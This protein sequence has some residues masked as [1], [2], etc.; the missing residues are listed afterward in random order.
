VGVGTSQLRSAKFSEQTLTTVT[1]TGTNSHLDN[2]V[3]SVTKLLSETVFII[4]Y[5]HVSDILFTSKNCIFIGFTHETE[6]AVNVHDKQIHFPVNNETVI[7][8]NFK[9]DSNKLNDQPR[10]LVVRVSNY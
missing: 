7:N 10:G 5:V 9:S 6:G 1:S 3:K 4:S 8:A 2:N